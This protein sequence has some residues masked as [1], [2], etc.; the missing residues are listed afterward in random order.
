VR[1]RPFHR[2][3]GRT[4]GPPS[5]SAG[6]LCGGELAGSPQTGRRG[7]HPRS[8][9]AVLR[10]PPRA[11]LQLRRRPSPP[12]SPCT[13][14]A[15]GRRA[16]RVHQRC[17]VRPS[18]Q[19]R[20]GECVRHDGPFPPASPRATTS[21]APRPASR[22]P[23]PASPRPLPLARAAAAAGHF[24]TAS[25]SPRPVRHQH[26]RP[27]CPRRTTLTAPRGRPHRSHHRENRGPPRRPAAEPAAAGAPPAVPGGFST[28]STA[29]LRP[30][31]PK[32]SAAASP[33]AVLAGLSTGKPTPRRR[34]P[35]RNGSL[36]PAEARG[37]RR[38]RRQQRV[39]SGPNH[40]IL[41]RRGRRGP[42]VGPSTRTER[43]RRPPIRLAPP[44]ACS[45]PQNSQPLTT[46]RVPDLPTE[47]PFQTHSTG[48][49]W[50]V[51]C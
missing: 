39:S 29:A 5:L 43:C 47:P 7:R 48:V 32:S 26:A 15:P 10:P 49:T 25:P 36:P 42:T 44:A 22:R 12:A 27:R 34:D 21:A 4:S 46:R 8:A 24:V 30:A 3:Y 50:P 19:L 28:R 2:H 11:S 37:H 16:R 38:E 40:P 6:Q 41:G 33:P 17:P 45:V 18:G 35:P 9:V 13:R 1:H 31:P 23:A 14:P 20:R 51:S